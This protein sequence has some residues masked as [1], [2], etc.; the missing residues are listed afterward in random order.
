MCQKYDI[1]AC[2]QICCAFA[3]EYYGYGTPGDGVYTISYPCSRDPRLNTAKQL[4]LNYTLNDI[5]AQKKLLTLSGLPTF[6]S[7]SSLVANQ[8][9]NHF[10][11]A[12]KSKQ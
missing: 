6:T 1:V 2:I 7:I 11:Q 8:M 10:L 4:K 5:Q 9:F 12:E 3:L